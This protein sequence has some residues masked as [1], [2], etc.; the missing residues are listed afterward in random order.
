MRRC[1]HHQDHALGRRLLQLRAGDDVVL[2]EERAGEDEAVGGRFVRH[3]ACTQQRHH[4]QVPDHA[5]HGV[6]DGGKVE[7]K[8]FGDLALR[9]ELLP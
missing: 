6:G 3:H 2:A 7:H 8:L 9:T 4:A 1:S 5:V